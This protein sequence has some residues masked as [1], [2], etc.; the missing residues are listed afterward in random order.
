[1]TMSYTRK[2]NSGAI[3]KNERK[4]PELQ[5]ADYTGTAL[6]DQVEYYIDAWINTSQTGSK[7]MSLKFKP[8]NFGAKI[9]T[10]QPEPAAVDFNDE[11]PF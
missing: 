1:M 10:T 7:Y 5:D 9:K 6:V 11:I 2:E 3:F 4:R 8:K